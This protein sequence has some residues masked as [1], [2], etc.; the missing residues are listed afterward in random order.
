MS[1]PQGGQDFSPRVQSQREAFVPPSDSILDLEKP[2]SEF[3]PAPA[4][5]DR[6]RAFVRESLGLSADWEPDVTGA[7]E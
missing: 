6:M 2:L 7:L 3:D 1:Y 4:I 5:A